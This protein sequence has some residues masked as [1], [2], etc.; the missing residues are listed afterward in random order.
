MVVES[1][2]FESMRRFSHNLGLN[3]AQACLCTE[4]YIFLQVINNF[5]RLAILDE[6]GINADLIGRSTL[7]CAPTG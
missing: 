3:L 7:R 5:A 1:E 2:R 6:V 4:C